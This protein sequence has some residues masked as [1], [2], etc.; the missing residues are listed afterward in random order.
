MK[1]FILRNTSNI[2]RLGIF[3][4]VIFALSFIYY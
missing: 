3:Y 4:T 1:N 2:K